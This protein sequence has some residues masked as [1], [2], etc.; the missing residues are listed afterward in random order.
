MATIYDVA[1]VAGV[2]TK[3]VSR[4]LNGDGPVGAKTRAAIEAAIDALG[5]VP[6]SAARM[7]RSSRSGIVGLITGA[8][9]SSVDL[10]QAAGLP[11]ILMVH[12]IQ[13]A[14]ARSGMTLM[15]AD[16]GDQFERVPHLVDTFL[17]HRV[18]G[19]IYVAN[20]HRMV[21]LP[22]VPQSTPL[23]LVNCR[24]DRGTP[25]VLP[26]DRRGAA[27]LTA[28]LIAA[29]HRRIGY[30][31]LREGMIA[32]H[33]RIEGYRDAIEAAGIGYDADLVRPCDFDLGEAGMQL[34]WDAVDRLLALPQPPTVLMCGNDMMANR[35]YGILRSRGLRLPED[36]SVAGYDNH[37]AIAESLLPPL[38][39]AE[40]PY[41]AMG[42]RAAES[43]LGLIAGQ[44]HAED[45]I[46]ITGAVHWRGSVTS[47]G[48]TSI[49]NL[50]TRQ[51]G[52]NP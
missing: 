36:M 7:M 19:L 42:L 28:R 22:R 32:S 20:Y 34:L 1:R 47:A 6:S 35:V 11:G 18:E 23:V 41:A 17:Q 49:H 2:S 38:T 14:L 46:L 52:E 37:R 24:D 9:S 16:S 27:A 51:G 8:I 29:G 30:L 33:L 39:T 13:Q 5:Y 15:I 4:V 50:K 43:L 40:L 48:V 10:G 3:T 12:G 31:A 21:D 25:S 45:P 44:G 26:D